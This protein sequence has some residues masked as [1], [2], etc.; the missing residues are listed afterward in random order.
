MTSLQGCAHARMCALSR[1]TRGCVHYP[2]AREDVCT[3]R[4]TREC[5]HCPDAREDVRIIR[6]TRECAHGGI[7]KMK[8]LRY[9]KYKYTYI[10]LDT[11]CFRY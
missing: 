6:S 7:E 8:I 3:I 5:S 10:G 4:Y 1:Y 2:D 9:L 11:V